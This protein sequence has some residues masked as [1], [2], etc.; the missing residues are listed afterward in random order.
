MRTGMC[1]ALPPGQLGGCRAPG[2]AQGAA[3]PEAR[4]SSAAR[5]PRWEGTREPSK[6]QE[7]ELSQ[8]VGQRL[9]LVLQACAAAWAEPDLR[10]PRLLLTRDHRNSMSKWL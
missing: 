3:V 9:Q 1:G 6:V 2:S 8:P 7:Q 10:G 4:G 5:Q